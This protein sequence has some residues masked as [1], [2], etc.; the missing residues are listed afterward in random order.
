[1]QQSTSRRR[2]FAQACAATLATGLCAGAALAQDAAPSE[3]VESVTSLARM[4][5]WSGVAASLVVIA[6]ASI[7]L[8]FLDRLTDGLG[9]SFAEYRL[10]IQKISAF[11]R[12][13]VYF[14]TILVVVMLSFRISREVLAILGGT[15]AVAIGFAMKDLVSSIVAGVMIMFDRP[16]QVGDRVTFGGQYGD[17]LNIGLRSVKLRTLGDSIVTIPNNLFLN[18]VTSCGNYGVAHMQIIVDFLI[19]PDSDATRA[20][21]IVREVAAT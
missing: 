17:I 13:A 2:L 10:T 16:F 11:T 14:A 6:A 12:F 9:A 19:D 3:A 15:A 8:G 20:R 18:E 7:S 1:M 4:I 5:R 21:D